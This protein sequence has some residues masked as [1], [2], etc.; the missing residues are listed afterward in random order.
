MMNRRLETF[1]ENRPELK[2]FNY[3]AEYGENLLNLCALINILSV[4]CM[5]THKANLIAK[6]NLFSLII[7]TLSIFNPMGLEGRD[8]MLYQIYFLKNLALMAGVIYMKIGDQKQEKP[9]RKQV[10]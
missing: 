2:S 8:K 4:A 7:T 6:M 1:F 3:I 9:W 10:I 5:F